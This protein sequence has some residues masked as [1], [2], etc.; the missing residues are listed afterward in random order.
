[1]FIPCW[2]KYWNH[3]INSQWLHSFTQYHHYKIL[4]TNSV[5]KYTTKETEVNEAVKSAIISRDRPN[6]FLL[7]PCQEMSHTKF[8]DSKS[9]H[10]YIGWKISSMSENKFLFQ[11]HVN[12]VLQWINIGQKETKYHP[13]PLHSF[14]LVVQVWFNNAVSMVQVIQHQMI[15]EYCHVR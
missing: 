14:V 9:Y 4:D 7:L 1:M 11:L 10:A 3:S 5:R 13:N 12:Q 15:W 8:A 6:L 2:Y